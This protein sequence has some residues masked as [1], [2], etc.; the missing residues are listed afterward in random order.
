MGEQKLSAIVQYLRRLA[1]ASSDDSSTD[2]ELLAAFVAHRD[3]AAFAAI[4][5][6]H[7]RMV[8]GV[9]HRMLGN[10]PDAEDVFQATFLVLIR[11]AATVH[12]QSSLAGWLFEVA[13]RLA[14]ET[15]NK[16]ARR[17]FHERRSLTCARPA[18]QE[19]SIQELALLLDSELKRLP[20]RYRD[21]CLLCYFEGRT[22][23]QAARLLG[24]SLRTVERRLEDARQ[25]LR[26][27]LIRQGVTFSAGLLATGLAHGETVSSLL[28]G[29]TVRAATAYAAGK[30]APS[31]RA[32]ILA[33]TFGRGVAMTRLT[34]VG[35]VLL[36]TATAAGTGARVQF[37]SA[38]L[39]QDGKAIT[40]AKGLSQAGGTA[41]EQDTTKP[42]ADAFAKRAWKIIDLIAQQHIDGIRK[43]AMILAG[44]KSVNLAAGQ[45]PPTDEAIRRIAGIATGEDFVVFLRANWPRSIT[46]NPASKAPET[47]GAIE[48]PRD[49]VLFHDDENTDPLQDAFLEG[50]LRSVPGT[51]RLAP[52]VDS[53]EAR[54]QEQISANRYVGIGIQLANNKGNRPQIRAAMPGGAARQAGIRSGD[55]IEEIDGKDTHNWPLRQVVDSLRGEEGTTVSVKVRGPDSKNS[56]NYTLKRAKVPF[57]HV[58]GYRRVSADGWSYHVEPDLPIA[59]LRVESPVSSTLHELRQAERKLRADGFQAVVID[60]RANGGGLL[61]HAVLVA[62]GLLDGR[63]MW[64]IQGSGTNPQ[65]EF[66]ADREC[67]FRDWPMVVLIDRR[68]GMVDALIA[69]ALQDNKRAILVGEPTKAMGYVSTVVQVRGEPLA[70]AIPTGRFERAVKERGWPVIPDQAVAMAD[71]EFQA[72]SDWQQRMFIADG[73]TSD[74]KDAPADPQLAKAIE[75]LRR[76]INAVPVSQKP[77]NP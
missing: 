22:A 31:L 39:T 73:P 6:R 23:D 71:Q 42:R 8:W 61:S 67:L 14:K 7:G 33:E 75:I 20:A 2:K 10:T 28:C 3:E 15:K 32:A 70:L 68:M 21:P 48:D 74:T 47:P 37:A 55:I 27:R 24:C 57:Q 4:V 69:A 25:L 30:L 26:A 13:S 18:A 65:T 12:W 45:L 52:P 34:L 59:Y 5:E 76:K 16:S 40:G 62:D 17:R 58:F 38:S 50:V 36:A 63:V 49:R 1:K 66:Q 46:K 44:L 19:T 64:R 41:E 53:K 35:L 51:A 43:E 72:L 11:K 54:V 60:L 29:S 77:G 56:R 9:C